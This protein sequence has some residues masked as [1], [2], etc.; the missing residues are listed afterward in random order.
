MSKTSSFEA[1]VRSY[2][3]DPYGHVNNAVYVS[4][5]EQGRLVFLRDRG[6]TYTSIPEELG[7]RVVVVRQDLSYKAPL[8]LGQS[9]RV[10][11]W[12]TALG[13]SS[14]TFAHEIHADGRPVLTGEVVMVCTE[15]GGRPIP[16]PAVLR[17]RLET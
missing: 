12:I 15:A 16:I 2:E 14:F 9:V 5:L 10:D 13:N 1:E 4:W 6:M 17:E 11:S 7:V 8:G 3:L